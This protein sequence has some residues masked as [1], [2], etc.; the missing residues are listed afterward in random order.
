MTTALRE[1]AAEVD[2]L[3]AKLEALR[4]S[5]TS[6]LSEAAHAIKN[7]LT[8][9]YSYLEILN[10]DLSEGLTK[11]QK[12]FLSIALENAEK[13]RRLVEDLAEVAALESESA[14]IDLAI[15]DVRMIVE[16]ACEE[17]RTSVEQA[18]LEL[19]I[20]PADRLSDV[21]IDKERLK[22]ALVRVLENSIRFTPAGGAIVLHA[23]QDHDHLVI[24]IRDTGVGMPA[25]RID[26]AL[27]AFVQLHREPG[28]TRES[29][30]LGLPL[31][32]R[33]VEAMGGTL[34]IGSVEGEGTT[35]TISLPVAESK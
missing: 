24:E 11:E 4:T 21:R 23:Q 10:T 34:T 6:F 30:G 13:L 17:V 27:R 15:S 2:A 31:S 28:E 33:Q 16:A 7:P 14:A 18:E 32:R 1:S 19:A 8:V 29:F 12:S 35:V 9:T 3:R 25:D 20:E 5:G 26:D 22:D